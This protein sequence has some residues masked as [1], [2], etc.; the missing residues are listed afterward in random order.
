MITAITTFFVLGGFGFWILAT[1]ASIV[2]IVGC[3]KDTIGL[4]IFATAV[5]IVLYHSA[6]LALITNPVVLTLGIVGWLVVGVA[7]SIWRLSVMAHD[8][9]DEY[10]RTGYGDPKHDLALSR[11]KGR[12]TNW[13]IYWPWSLFW[14]FF[15]DFFNQLYKAMSGIY[16]RVI[17]KAL[18]NLRPE[19]NR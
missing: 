16:Q 3:E 7:N 13:I 6:L 9:V 12:I 19:N 2:F 10:N 15:R 1:L 8:V 18:S 5:L 4:S 17:D 11:N 14:N